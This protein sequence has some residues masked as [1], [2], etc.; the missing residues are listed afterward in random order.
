MLQLFEDNKKIYGSPSLSE[1]FI[2]EDI[3]V[4]RFKSRQLMRRLAL[5]PRYPKRFK[6]TTDSNHNEAIAPNPLKRQL[7]V[8]Q[9]NKVWTTDITYVW[10]LEG[11]LYVAVDI[12]LFSRQ[13]VGWSIDDHMKMQQSMSRKGNCWDNAPTER[14]FRSLKH[15][16]I[17]YERFKTKES[18][19]LSI[20]DY[21]AFYNGRRM[22]SNK[23]IN[24]RS[25]MNGN[26][27]TNLLNKVPCFS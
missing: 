2:D 9:P 18:A 16:Q 15:E 24:L 12:D 25:N 4:G 21:L 5:K 20:I 27:I 11:L 10:T 6:V 17:N 22:H 19:K 14:F 3:K 1:A 13:V 8:A 26:S 23:V 7:D